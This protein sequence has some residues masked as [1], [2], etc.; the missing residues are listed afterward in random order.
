[1]GKEF[2]TQRF[3]RSVT[4]PEHVGEHLVETHPKLADFLACNPSIP[5][6]VF[7]NIKLAV[8]PAKEVLRRG[9]PS[10]AEAWIDNRKDNRGTLAAAVV[11]TFDLSHDAQLKLASKNIQSGGVHDIFQY[12]S[13]SARCKMLNRLD[14]RTVQD[15]L[16]RNPDITD[17]EAVE[18]AVH[19]ETGAAAASTLA[20]LVVA[21]PTIIDPLLELNTLQSVAV[22][23]T[24]NLSAEQATRAAE[25]VNA[26][27]DAVPSAWFVRQ[28]INALLDQPALPHEVRDELWARYE[29]PFG[30]SLRRGGLVTSSS[31]Y[32]P[33]CKIDEI[34][35]PVVVEA[36][37]LR[38]L[39]NIAGRYARQTLLVDA[40]G[41]TAANIDVV[42]GALW[43]DYR[44]TRLAVL[45]VERA[46]VRL[47][48]DVHTLTHLGRTD[49]N[50]NLATYSATTA[51]QHVLKST[52]ET[53]RRR[54]CGTL[55][56]FN[57][58]KTRTCSGDELVL[59][60]IGT[61][62]AFE[63]EQMSM[64]LY[65]AFTAPGVNTNAA[66]KMCTD[67]LYTCTAERT[68][69]ELTTS[70]VSLC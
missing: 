42:L 65:Q 8:H 6:R 50:K 58:T 41:C 3:A 47:G 61:R 62:S 25:L 7:A 18:A 36:F 1:M 9:E 27:Y 34:E 14:S 39:R 21:R 20:E 67:M 17:A 48:I 45:A 15:F 5:S 40:P 22:A 59:H 32:A 38:D 70:V 29:A 46:S 43:N 31:I 4:F 51:S 12:V 30:V 16:A 64:Y 66:Y 55:M 33:Q 57:D 13:D 49:H 19:V 44:S 54:S 53:T 60:F 52:T 28:S 2:L 10:D 11:H 24:G 23:V 68:L 37:A 69:A 56:D 35:D 26:A 63:I